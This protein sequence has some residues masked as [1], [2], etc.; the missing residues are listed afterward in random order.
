MQCRTA[1]TLGACWDVARW[2]PGRTRRVA[3][4]VGRSQLAHG[5][6]HGQLSFRTLGTLYSCWNPQRLVSSTGS[7][8]RGQHNWMAFKIVEAMC[9]QNSAFSASGM[10]IAGTASV[11]K[12]MGKAI[13]PSAHL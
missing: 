10:S 12:I 6:G 1:P 5:H 3:I 9:V 11:I 4:Q 13:L 2:I 8:A 7:E